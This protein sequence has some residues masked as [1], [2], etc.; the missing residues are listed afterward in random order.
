MNY[1]KNISD[2]LALGYGSKYQL[3]R[4]LGWHRN[5]FNH[6]I[7]QSAHISSNINWLDFRF[8]GP[9]DKELLNFDFIETVK[10]EWRE[11]WKCGFTGLNWDAVGITEDETYVFVEAKANSEELKSSS[12][13]SEKSIESNNRVIEKV[14]KKYSVQKTAEDWNRDVYQLANR[15][16]AIDFLIQKKI[17]AI[18]VYVLFENG[19]E[20]NSSTNKSVSKE[21]WEKTIKNEFDKAGIVGTELE[22]M[23]SVCIIN[24]NKKESNL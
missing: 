24:C 16:V 4:M 2:K 13:G 6:T 15:L 21:E 19:Y 23:V 10:D 8:N 17:K 9:E 5:E 14:I 7:A 3:L 22:K 12:G 11:Y 18:L 1:K 20:F